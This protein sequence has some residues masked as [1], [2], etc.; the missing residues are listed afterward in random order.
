MYKRI[1]I[2]VDAQ[3]AARAAI[4]QGL[5]LAR[6]HDA[7]VV[8]FTALAQPPLPLVDLAPVEPLA[9]QEFTREARTEAQRVLATAREAADEAGVMS[10]QV[11]GQGQN[12]S[13]AIAETARKRRCE[14]V[15]VASDGHNALVRLLT[16]S[17]IPGLITASTIPI[18]VCPGSPEAGGLRDHASASADE[19][20]GHDAAPSPPLRR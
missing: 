14:L 2:V 11:V 3:P 4:D 5:S 16:G 7:E 9:P 10:H 1:L 19:S 6:H 12:P 13:L 17:V 15:V 8:F 20:T 18:L